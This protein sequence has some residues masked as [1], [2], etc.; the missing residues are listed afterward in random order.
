MAFVRVGVFKAQPAKLD[1]LR[2]IYESEAIPIIR[3][4]AGNLGAFLLQ[5]RD[6][7]ASFMAMTVWQTQQDAEAYEK[8]G[9][10]AAMVGKIRHAFAG[11]PTL[12]TYVAFGF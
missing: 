4:A 7:P 5:Q 11:A 10:A 1:E 12:T 8:S 3:S 2:S 6:D 9:Q